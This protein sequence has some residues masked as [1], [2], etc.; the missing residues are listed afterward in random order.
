MINSQLETVDLMPSL[1]A[2]IKFDFNL[3]SV[4]VLPCL[5]DAFYQPYIKLNKCLFLFHIGVAYEDQPQCLLTDYL[6][7]FNSIC[8][9]Q[10]TI[11]Q[12]LG[13]DMF[14]EKG[15]ENLDKIP[16]VFNRLTGV[17]YWVIFRTGAISPFNFKKGTIAANFI[18]TTIV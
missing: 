1:S 7:L 4:Y 2:I 3:A 9:Q 17:Y 14:K 16:D 18:H 8:D 10:A 13:E 5:K 6:K 15:D 11:R 12:L